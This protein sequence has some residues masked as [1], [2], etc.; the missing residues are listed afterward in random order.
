MANRK[1]FHDAI[2]VQ[3]CSLP[4]TQKKQ[5][6]NAPDVSCHLTSGDSVRRP[7]ID[8]K[9]WAVGDTDHTTTCSEITQ[10]QAGHTSQAEEERALI[11]L[12]KKDL[13]PKPGLRRDRHCTH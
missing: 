1:R 3:Y 5:P 4:Q 6:S 2:A 10:P 8:W 12:A 7:G 9:A 11:D 13:Q